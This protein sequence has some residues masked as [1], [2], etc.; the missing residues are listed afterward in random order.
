MFQLVDSEGVL[1]DILQQHL[2][3]ELLPL[4]RKAVEQTG[5]IGSEGPGKDTR[6]SE[7]LAGLLALYSETKLA[8]SR[9]APHTP[10]T[11][12]S[13]LGKG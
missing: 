12:P 11:G 5:C 10:G 2:L 1:Y 4:S 8:T 7:L 13:R 6:S 9:T 3:Y